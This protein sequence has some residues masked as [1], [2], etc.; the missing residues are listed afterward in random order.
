MALSSSQNSLAWPLPPGFCISSALTTPGF[1]RNRIYARSPV[2]PQPLFIGHLSHISLIWSLSLSVVAVSVR[3]SSVAMAFVCGSNDLRC[4]ARG[5]RRRPSPAKAVDRP[6][7]SSLPTNDEESD[8][9][10]D[11][12]AHFDAI[13]HSKM[14]VHPLFHLIPQAF[15]DDPSIAFFCS[16]LVWKAIGVEFSWVE[17]E[18]KIQVF[19]GWGIHGGKKDEFPVGMRV[20]VVDDVLTYSKVLERMHHNCEQRKIWSNHYRYPHA[21]DGWFQIMECMS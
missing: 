9:E 10:I 15:L 3:R 1:V 17:K 14:V 2:L 11:F 18:K 4:W 8:D 21:R 13:N 19:D 7:S 5:L 16:I 12:E 6:T 20:L